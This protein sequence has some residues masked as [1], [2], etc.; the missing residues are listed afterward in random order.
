MDKKHALEQLQTELLTTLELYYN[1][2]RCTSGGV[3]T[4]PD[5][6]ECVDPDLKLYLKYAIIVYKSALQHVNYL[7]ESLT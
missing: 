6:I 3:L 1:S 2:L 7:L 4:K 5:S